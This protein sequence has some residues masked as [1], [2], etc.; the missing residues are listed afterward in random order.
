MCLIRAIR[1]SAGERSSVRSRARAE[2]SSW[3]I[4]LSHS[5]LVW[6]WTM[7]S[8]SSCC[9]RVRQRLL[10]RQQHVEPQV[11]AVGH[12]AREVAAGC[13]PRGHACSVCHPWQQPS[14]HGSRWPRLPSHPWA[15]TAGERTRTWV[16][17]WPC[18]R[19]AGAATAAARSGRPDPARG[20]RRPASGAPCVRRQ[21]PATLCVQP[22]PSAGDVL[23]R[24][25]GPGA[26]WALDGMPATARAPTTTRPA[27][28][29]TTTRR[30]PAGWRS[31]PPLAHRRTGLVMEALVPS[32]LE[33]KVTGKQAFGSFRELVRAPRRART[34]PGRVAAADAAAEPGHDR[35]HPVVGVAAARRPARPVAHRGHRLPARVVA[36]AG[37]RGV[38]PRRPTGGCGRSAGSACGPA[39]RCASVRSATPTRSASATTTSPTGSAGRSSATT[40]PTRRW[41]RLLEPYRPQR[42]RAAAMAMA[43][44]QARPRR[45]P[46]MSI[47]THLP[48][49]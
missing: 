48:T 34:G 17:D 4:S 21:G 10:G 27:S 49:R 47:P 25:W 44:G 7:K 41:P 1:L 23:G 22:R 38:G 32:I 35:R 31:P 29:R 46:R 24:A 26:E 11:V 42:G 2:R 37:G 30:S 28:S 39:P 3:I 15:P 5:S 16:P 20:R 12:R 6:C 18:A 33:Q 43:G 40:S 8:S 36:G 9:W 14:C 45:G 19:G 13:P